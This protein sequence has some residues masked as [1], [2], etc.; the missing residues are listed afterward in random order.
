MNRFYI[1]EL[2]SKADPFDDISEKD[3]RQKKWII[4]KEK[5]GFDSR[6]TWSLDQVMTEKIYERL[7]LY[8]ENASEVVNL[9]AHK[10][11][12]EGVEYTQ[13][14][15]IDMMIENARFYLLYEYN[16]F[17]NEEN[18]NIDLIPGDIPLSELTSVN[19]ELQASLAKQRLWQIWAIVQHVM[20]W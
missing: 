14:E 1:D 3:V 18:F 9:E 12:F 17:E 19:L 13:R 11:F 5:L 2:K 8:L 10:F 15:L 16:A 4:E 20:W 7:C 6:D